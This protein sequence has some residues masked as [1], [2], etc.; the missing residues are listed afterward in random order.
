MPL[1][2]SKYP[3]DNPFSLKQNNTTY[4]YNIISK[5][6]YPSK[7]KT[8]YTS[9]RSRDGTTYRISDNYVKRN[10]DTKAQL[11][12][13]H[14]F[15]L[16]EIDVEQ[17]REKKNR[18][19]PF[20]PFNTLGKSMKEKRSRAFSKQI[21]IAFKNEIHK[22]YNPMDQPILQELRFNVQEK[23]YVVDYHNRNRD[24]K[25]IHIEAVTEIVDQGPISRKSYRNLAAIQY[26]LPRDHD[27]SDTR[28]KI[29][30]EM[31]QK[32]SVS[33]LNI[34]NISL[35]TT[36]EPPDINDQEIE[37]EM[38]R[39]IGNAGYRRITDIL[40]FVIPD[41]LNRQVLN[42]NNPVIHIRI[43]GDG[44]NVGRKIKHVMVTCAILDDVSNTHKAN[45]HHTIILCPGTENYDLFKTIMKPVINELDNLVKNGLD[46]F[47]IKW[48]IEPF[49][50][51]DW[52]F[53]CIILGFNAP[54]AN[55]FCPWCLCTKKE[56][57]IKDKVYTIEKNM[58]QL[59]AEKP[60]PGHSKALL[61]PM[62]PLDC[63]VPDELHVMLRIWD[64]LWELAIQELKSENRYDEH[65]R[66]IIVR[67][68]KRISVRFQFWQDHNVENWIYTSLMGDDKEKVLRS[69]NF[70]VI[71]DNE[72]A[73]LINRLWRDFHTLYTLMKQ[74]G[75]DPAAFAAQAKKW[76]ELFLT[77]YQGEPNTASF[78]KGLYRP[79]DVSPYIHVLVH[80]IAEFMER[81]KYFGFAAFSCEAVEKKNHNH[82]ATFFRRTMKDGGNGI[83][84]KSAIFEILDYENRS[85]YTLTAKN[86]T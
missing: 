46:D 79:K 15:G 71:F 67:E 50:S 17:E 64:R 49:F 86:I 24:E 52:K 16:N 38:M 43:S 66:E 62:I 8:C 19:H 57:G 51:S 31:N 77:P 54:N 72:R 81:H 6:F 21:G 36:N 12:G 13:V 32:V 65:N 58:E 25:N 14:V 75:T 18:S 27:V 34:A 70:E 69:F 11:S 20:R 59:K 30:E 2:N 74:P 9:T 63:Y 55:Y 29:N 48:K 10:P 4:T 3:E 76:L 33:V 60:P 80:H 35:I 61:I 1:S 73:M 44:R 37:E 39:Y 85:L 41:L 83:E 5:G 68:M 22:F 82:V 53:L 84:R 23:N 28:K 42:I 40:R 7:N 56:I 47:G 26:E 78:K 45:Y